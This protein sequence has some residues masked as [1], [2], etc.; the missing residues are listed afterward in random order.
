M[1]LCV[2]LGVGCSVFMANF[3]F[4]HDRGM[5][6]QGVDNVPFVRCPLGTP[7]GAP[8]GLHPRTMRLDEA[9]AACGRCRIWKAFFFFHGA[10]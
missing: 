3:S 2:F 1:P 6:G 8:H 7:F 5:V 4:T 10:S 9:E